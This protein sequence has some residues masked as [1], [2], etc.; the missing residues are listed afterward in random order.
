MLLLEN[1]LFLLSTK[2]EKCLQII[3]Q[4]ITGYTRVK[5]TEEYLYLA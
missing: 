1:V 5:V 3:L 2:E 4:M